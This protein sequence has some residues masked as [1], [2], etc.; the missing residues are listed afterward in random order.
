M[1]SEQVLRDLF[2]AVVP[3]KEKTAKQ[4]IDTAIAQE[5]STADSPW[6]LL[7]LDGGLVFASVKLD[8]AA[9]GRGDKLLVVQGGDSWGIIGRWTGG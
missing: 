3:P 6:E 2:E 1:N 8:G 5:P 9:W 7:L 4:R